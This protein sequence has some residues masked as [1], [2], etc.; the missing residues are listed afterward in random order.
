MSFSLRQGLISWVCYFGIGHM[1]G[2]RKNR[3]DENF[4]KAK[5]G[6]GY[7]RFFKVWQFLSKVYQKI[8]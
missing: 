3:D 5:V 4:A 6:E 1:N 8:K 7:P 2:R